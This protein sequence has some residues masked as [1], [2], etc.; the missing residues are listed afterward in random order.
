MPNQIFVPP[1]KTENLKYFK[2][3]FDE[4]T[5]A[6]LPQR[7]SFLVNP[8][9]SQKINLDD[10]TRKRVRN[11]FQILNQIFYSEKH[12]T[13]SEILLAYLNLLLSELNIVYHYCPT[14]I[15]KG[16]PF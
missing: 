3:L 14:K 9:N 6:L 1:A 2:V 16:R 13:D 4:N 15:F 7:F 12:L 8:L 5:L 10:A 11:V